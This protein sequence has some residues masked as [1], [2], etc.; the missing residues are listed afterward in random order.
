MEAKHFNPILISHRGLQMQLF[1]FD[2]VVFLT[3]TAVWFVLAVVTDNSPI[4][5]TAVGAT[6][7]GAFVVVAK[8]LTKLVELWWKDRQR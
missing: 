5:A 6:I 7:T 8:V 1:D 4:L 2:N 3:G